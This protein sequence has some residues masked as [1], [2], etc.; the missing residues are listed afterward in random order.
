MRSHPCVATR[1]RSG[2]L[3]IHGWYYDIGEG[4][5]QQFDEDEETFVPLDQVTEVVNQ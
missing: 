2:T 1:L 3:D 4:T 5:I